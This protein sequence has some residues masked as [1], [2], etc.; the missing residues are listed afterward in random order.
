MPR[1]N[2]Q[3]GWLVSV[4]TGLLVGA[5]VLVSALNETNQPSQPM[6][7]SGNDLINAGQVQ[8][9]AR[10]P[11]LI[12]TPSPPEEPLNPYQAEE[13]LRA[14]RL[15]QPDID[16]RS[17][18][19]ADII[20]RLCL[21]GFTQ[22]AWRLI[23]SDP[24]QVRDFQL[25]A[26]FE[27][28]QINTVD[29]FA[30]MQECRFNSDIQIAF[31]CYLSRFEL[32]EI[33]V[34]LQDPRYQ[35]IF[36]ELRDRSYPN[37]ISNSLSM[38]F[39]NKIIDAPYLDQMDLLKQATKSHSD[40]MLNDSGFAGVLK[41]AR[42]ISS[43][44]RWDVMNILNSNDRHVRVLRDQIIAD[45]IRRD[46]VAALDLVISTTGSSRLQ[47]TQTLLPCPPSETPDPRKAGACGSN[48][49]GVIDRPGR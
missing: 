14:A 46:A 35:E 34:L 20:K 27:N 8:S 19:A 25:T 13:M 37:L 1:S 4:A 38:A 29:A 36:K 48:P 6:D 3:F 32:A 40:G 31:S 43:E 23:E 5:F 42:Q 21:G 2:T 47:D 22:E 28:A 11:G 41:L 15:N 18:L 24:G 44:E 39:Q 7:Q 12:P 16:Q 30:R 45:M 10:K 33:N 49:C 17:G 26:F 9:S